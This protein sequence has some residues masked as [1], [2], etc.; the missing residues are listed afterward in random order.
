M[1]DT[2]TQSFFGQSTGL[3][4]SSAYKSEPFIFL[5]CIK[6]KTDGAWEK[7][8][9][10]EGKTIK[11]N[12]EEIVMLLQILCQKANSWSTYHTFNEIKTQLSFNW[13]EN[14]DGDNDPKLWI[15]IGEYKKM[16]NFAQVEIFRMLLEHIL[17]EKIEYATIGSKNN[18]KGEPEQINEEIFSKY[19]DESELN[20]LDGLDDRETESK[21]KNYIIKPKTV[22]ARKDENKT[23]FYNQPNKSDKET[24]RING[25]I[26]GETGKALLIVL[27]PGN[28]IWIPKS[29][30]HSNYNNEKNKL[31]SFEIE[32][33]ILKKR[34]LLTTNQ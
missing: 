4:I 8:S 30:I 2:H 28:E 5:K 6:K 18:D 10:G 15:N 19:Q 20:A 11:C 14:N 3:T 1:S 21:K 13:A 16:L 23:T 32:N 26:K 27:S 34:D 29:K 31:Q 12:L 24:T 9:K 25:L 22:I 17:K 33:W 7:F